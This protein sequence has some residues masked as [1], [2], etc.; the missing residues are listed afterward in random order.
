ME[1]NVVEATETG[2]PTNNKQ[3]KDLCITV[4]VDDTGGVGD[5]DKGPVIIQF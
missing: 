1:K 4:E 2:T 5:G 3:N